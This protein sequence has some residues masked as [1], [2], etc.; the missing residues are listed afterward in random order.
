M[1]W[2]YIINLRNKLYTIIGFF[3][4]VTFSR[5]HSHVL[6]FQHVAFLFHVPCVYAFA[7]PEACLC[8]AITYMHSRAGRGTTL[9]I[10]PPYLLFAALLLG[11]A[12]V[13][14]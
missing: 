14:I 4:N 13:N 11:S 5:V 1:L 9:H 8:Q 12:A 10:G 3:T 7:V 6:T 2:I